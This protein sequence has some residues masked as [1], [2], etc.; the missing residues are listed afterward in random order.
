MSATHRTRAKRE[1]ELE[2]SAE[3]GNDDEGS[4]SSSN[5]SSE[6]EEEDVQKSEVVMQKRKKQM[7][8]KKKLRK[9]TRYFSTCKHAYRLKSAEITSVRTKTTWPP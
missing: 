3:A 1:P 4:S 6:A 2:T 8:G 5:S 9:N 7:K